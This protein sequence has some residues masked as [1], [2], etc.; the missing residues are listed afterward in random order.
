[1]YSSRGSGSLGRIDK[2]QYV[3]RA[4]NFMTKGKLI[5]DEVPVEGL[6]LQS[7]DAFAFK[8]IRERRGKGGTSPDRTT[9]TNRRGILTLRVFG[10]SSQAEGPNQG[11]RQ[12]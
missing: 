1:M 12:E 6:L 9:C 2:S 4:Y 7:Q 10:K 5:T 11:N 3:R 8:K